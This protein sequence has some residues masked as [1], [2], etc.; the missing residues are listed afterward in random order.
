MA[1]IREDNGKHH[2]P[3]LPHSNGNILASG[4]K[5]GI[6]R[7]VLV[8]AVLF[9]VVLVGYSR[10]WTSFAKF[11]AS[12]TFQSVT[13]KLPFGGKVVS[14][15]TNVKPYQFSLNCPEQKATPK[16]STS[17][18]YPLTDN[19]KETISTQQ[20]PEYFR[21]I[22][23]DL[24]PWK[25]EGISRS[26][27]ESAKS[28]A[29]FRL[30]IISGKAYVEIYGRPYQTRDLFTMWGFVQLLRSF[31]GKLPDLELMFRCGDEPMIVRSAHQASNASAPPA[32]F[33][34]SGNSDS[35]V[36][37][38][39]DW[40]FWGWAETNVKPWTTMLDL[41]SEGNIRTK[42]QDR[43]PYA[44]W[45]GNPGVGFYRSDLMTCNVSDIHDWNARLYVQ[46]W[47]KE[48]K[49]G[50]KHSKLEDQCTHRYKIYIEGWAWSV[51]EKYILACDSMTLIVKPS[52]Y[53]F[54]SR[55]LEPMK[56][57]WP[58]KTEKLC[59]SIEFAVEWGN[60]HPDKAQA[61]GKAGSEFIRE[62][63]KMEYVYDYMFHS[64]NEY[65]KLLKFKPR[66]PEG[67][68]E[69]C[70]EPLVCP[71]TGLWK[72]FLLDSMVKSPRDTPPCTMPPPFDNPTLQALRE[73]N[74]HII[75]QVD[76][77]RSRRWQDKD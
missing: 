11:E 60:T 56:H 17:A 70:A 15:R 14:S 72:E 32:L 63:L 25:Q 5:R 68:V 59:R 19:A 12:Q 35:L 23:Q 52:F 62:S 40:T 34:Y 77:W 48:K 73:R 21:W 4:C 2:R 55:S 46:D 47:R 57:Y 61:I 36:I 65:A 3:Q 39:P 7:W 16:C 38:F 45:K 33:Q 53:D 58:L 71:Q 74:E 22:H 28:V 13:A 8:A 42:W 27:L 75:E 54:F 1:D 29:Q 50:F 24:E 43:S 49:Q 69:L 30:V 26:T 41:I 76:L 10:I 20:C 18:D 37:V 67:A 51:S 6:K 9:S 64:L 66:I 31:P 44:Y